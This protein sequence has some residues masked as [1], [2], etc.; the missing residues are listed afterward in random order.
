MTN[1]YSEVSFY[2]FMAVIHAYCIEAQITV[3]FNDKCV[4]CLIWIVV[5][6]YLVVVP[7]LNC[8]FISIAG[9]FQDC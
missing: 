7:F 4:A 3:P 9:L 5:H 6:S 2:Y 1:V 8:C